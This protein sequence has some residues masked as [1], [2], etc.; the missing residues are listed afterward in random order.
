SFP[1]GLPSGCNLVAVTFTD[2]KFC[3]DSSTCFSTLVGCSGGTSTRRP[4][5]GGIFYL[6]GVKV[7]LVPVQNR[8][9]HLQFLFAGLGFS[10]N[11]LKTCAS[12]R[13]GFL[14]VW[15]VLLFVAV[16]AMP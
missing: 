9:T 4:S 6:A 7:A 12:C 13:A 2:S 1:L 16:N 15:H 5:L 10:S 3:V 11:P 14:L 8:Q